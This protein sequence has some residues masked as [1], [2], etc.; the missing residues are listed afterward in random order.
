MLTMASVPAA[1]P[2]VVGE[3]FTDMVA[4]WL[5]FNVVGRVTP[6]IVNALPDRFACEIVRLAVPVLVMVSE[7]VELCP[8]CT[9]P[10]L[11]AVGLPLRW[12]AVF[13][14]PVSAMVRA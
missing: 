1:L 10:K 12:P 5:A 9:L 4:L 7:I 6:L 3:N 14:V 13:A 2:A 11:T 8:T